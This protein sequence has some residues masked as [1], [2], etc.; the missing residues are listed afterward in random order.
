MTR[1]FILSMQVIALVIV[2]CARPT[3]LLD[4]RLLALVLS[5]LPFAWAGNRIGI[6]IY[7]R[8]SQ[9]SY[10]RVT[11]AALGVSGVSLVL[12]SVVFA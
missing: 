1:P 8:T 5:S 7:R 3:A 11:L 4:P 6:A 2:A 9:P 10:R 12:K